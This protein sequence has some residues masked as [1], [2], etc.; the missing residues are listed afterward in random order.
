MDIKSKGYGAIA[1][2]VMRSK[3]VSIGAKTVYA[4]LCSYAGQG[5][6]AFPKCKTMA[7][8][9]QINKNN[10][11]KYLRE[12][13]EMEIINIKRTPRY[14]IYT[15]LPNEQGSTWGRSEKKSGNWKG[16]VYKY[17][18]KDSRLTLKAKAI[19]SYL[20]S[21]TDIMGNDVYPHRDVLLYDLS[22]CENT[23]YAHLKLL[24]EYGYIKTTQRKNKGRYGVCDYKIC[25]DMPTHRKAGK[26]EISADKNTLK[27]QYSYS[28]TSKEKIRNIIDMEYQYKQVVATAEIKNM[29]KQF[30]DASEKTDY[31]NF[32]KNTVSLSIDCIHKL[33]NNQNYTKYNDEIDYLLIKN[34]LQEKLS[35]EN[36]CDMLLNICE[37]FKQIKY[38]KT[39][40]NKVIINFA[41]QL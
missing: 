32:A 40:I 24:K 16:T 39:Y 33:I 37:H 25:M 13:K 34:N 6:L 17:A 22:I 15:L 23:Y 12:L 26:G 1:Q 10:L 19:Y 2:N 21:F 4:Y 14:N 20:C 5:A 7:N 11:H 8:D 38:L 18:M 30:V 28:Y 41:L 31:I 36:F 9:L 3:E 35:K 29:C 27:K